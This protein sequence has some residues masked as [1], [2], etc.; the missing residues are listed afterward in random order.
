M[1]YVNFLP[2][3]LHLLY[4]SIVYLSLFYFLFFHNNRHHY[5]ICVYHPNEWEV[6]ESRTGLKEEELEENEEMVQKEEEEVF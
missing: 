5:K 6:E 4:L 2:Y 3:S 1:H